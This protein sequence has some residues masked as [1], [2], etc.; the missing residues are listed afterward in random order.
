MKQKTYPA[1]Y[2]SLV[3]IC[4]KTGPDDPILLTYSRERGFF[5]PI[6]NRLAYPVVGKVISWK[7]RYPDKKGW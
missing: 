5:E 6:T 7:Y 1:E 4:E 3:C 2:R